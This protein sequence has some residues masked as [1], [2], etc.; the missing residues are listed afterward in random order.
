MDRVHVERLEVRDL[1]N[2]REAAVTLEPGLN[3]FVGRNAQGKT[4]LLEA[5]ALLARGR[6]FRTERVQ[7]LIRRGAPFAR[8][9]GLASAAA[10]RPVALQVDVRPEGRTLQVDGGQVGPAAYQG[11]LEA[12][13]YSTDRL[14]IVRGAMKERRSYLDRGASALWP[15]YRRTVR[16]YEQVVRRA[17]ASH[18]GLTS[19]LAR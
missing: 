16:E 12:V 3:V 15:A 2:I 17:L 14:R 18:A 7:Q 6:S 19:P 1:R 9:A 11:R 5:V 10:R 4:S 8:A 13:V